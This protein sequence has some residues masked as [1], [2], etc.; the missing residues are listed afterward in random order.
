MNSAKN[1][2]ILGASRHDN[3]GDDLLASE[4]KKSLIK[5][6]VSYNSISILNPHEVTDQIISNLDVLVVGGGGLIYS[7]DKSNVINYTSI[8]KATKL[9]K[10]E[11][12]MICVGVQGK[13]DPDSLASYREAFD[14]CNFITTRSSSDTKAILETGT[15]AKVFTGQDLGFLLKASYK[16]KL[17][18]KKDTV[19]ERPL[20]IVSLMN[21]KIDYLD[22]T[23]IKPTFEQEVEKYTDYI[24][25]S[26][27]TLDKYFS[28]HFL[29]QAREDGPLYKKIEDQGYKVSY[30]SSEAN[31]KG[32][33]D[34]MGIYKS[35]DLILTG[36]FHGLVAAIAY[37]KAFVNWSLDG[38]KQKNLLDDLALNSSKINF[39]L[40][41][42]YT[43]DIFSLLTRLN[44]KE[45]SYPK[46]LYR[47]FF[48]ML[49]IKKG[50]RVHTRVLK[51]L[52]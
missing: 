23:A 21:W 36:R 10:K 46:Q 43:S 31:L 24:L 14:S 7:H 49:S 13:K 5:L 6:G 15:T 29:S 18:K 35:A 16:V 12:C 25:G 47:S 8:I 17:K 51:K 38:G 26:L 39:N 4:I 27:D 28:L 32:V 45:P 22:Y 34:F 40:K 44:L 42:G 19:E 37:G 33:D 52:L 20:L 1:F 41:E 3:V 9:K 30:Y 2:V 48:L 11:I 50:L